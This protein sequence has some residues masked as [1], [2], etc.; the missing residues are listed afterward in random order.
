M[1]VYHRPESCNRCRGTNAFIRPSYDSGRLHE[2][3]TK[4][5]VCGFE[6][7]WAYGFF[8]SGSE[9]ISKCETYTVGE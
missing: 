6:D 3:Q 5:T 2:T 1:T 7:Y 8:E 4:C 9:I